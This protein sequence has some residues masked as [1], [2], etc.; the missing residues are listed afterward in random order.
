MRII[1]F[2]L[3]V[4]Q[5]LDR[6]KDQTRRLGW[7]QAKPGMRLRGVKKAMGRKPDQALED[8]ALVEGRRP[9]L[10]GPMEASS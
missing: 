7:R 4:P 2:A 9:D 8:I 6:T 3:T 1:S 10:F 5:V